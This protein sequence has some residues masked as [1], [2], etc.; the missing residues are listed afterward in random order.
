MDPPSQ[1][2]LLMIT[3]YLPPM[4][5]LWTLQTSIAIGDKRGKIFT[6][7]LGVLILDYIQ[8][9]QTKLELATMIKLNI[10]KGDELEGIIVVGIPIGTT[11]FVNTQLTT[12]TDALEAATIAISKMILNKQALGQ[13]YATCLL[14]RTPFCMMADVS[15]NA[16]YQSNY[17]LLEWTSPT[18]EASKKLLC[19]I[20]ST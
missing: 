1:L 3:Q 12:F 11:V 14:A 9:Q 18:S 16:D 13:I 17:T 10:E 5:I 4:D 6:N 19:T 8:D 2:L 20:M 15:A 7:I